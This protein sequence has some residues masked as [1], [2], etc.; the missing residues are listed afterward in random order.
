MFIQI[1]HFGCM[2]QNNVG[3][4]YRGRTPPSSFEYASMNGFYSPKQA[5]A[6]CERDIQCGG[7]T[8]RGKKGATD[9]V[10][11]VYF[12]HF[13]NK[14]SSYLTPGLKHPH[15]T[16]YIVGSKD[17][18]IISGLYPTNDST[19]WRK[20]NRYANVLL[21]QYKNIILFILMTK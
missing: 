7:F 12:F 19:K 16:T 15:W 8:F 17:H 1:C 11:K 18:I 5:Q 2:T 10:S 14:T 9:I 4:W 3:Q 21:V 20:L 6:I 13:I